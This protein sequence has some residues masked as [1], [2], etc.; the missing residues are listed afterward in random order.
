M[1]STVY[2]NHNL[3]RKIRSS[4]YILITPWSRDALG[5]VCQQIDVQ[6]KSYIDP[7]SMQPE[8]FCASRSTKMPA[9][10]TKETYRQHI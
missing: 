8:E 1:S 5:A 9:Y 3:R 4:K 2:C 7:H 10:R 6:T